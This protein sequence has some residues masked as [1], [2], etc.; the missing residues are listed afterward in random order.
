MQF[1]QVIAL[2]T[3]TFG[4]YQV[5]TYLVQ[6]IFLLQFAL[7]GEG[8]SEF[9]VLSPERLLF[10]LLYVQ[11]QMVEMK[12]SWCTCCMGYRGNQSLSC[13]LNLFPTLS[14][15]KMDHDECCTEQLHHQSVQ[16]PWFLYL[17]WACR[18]TFLVCT[19]L[20]GANTIFNKLAVVLPLQR[21]VGCSLCMTQTGSVFLLQ[22]VHLI[23]A[24][25]FIKPFQAKSTL[26]QKSN[27]KHPF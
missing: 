24:G 4:N 22:D 15:E 19:L 5:V 7:H 14:T 11:N 25:F 2:L 20:Q 6:V 12:Q 23:S 18:L 13:S 21:G 8:Q 17:R 27:A 3:N 16:A 9:F 1:K 10:C 26:A